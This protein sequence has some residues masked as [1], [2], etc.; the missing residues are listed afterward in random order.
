MGGFN[1]DMLK[2]E[3]NISDD[4]TPMAMIAVGYY[5]STDSLVEPY[6]ER[7]SAARERQPLEDNFRSSKY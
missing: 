2:A 5:G 7:E 6:R 3:F 1:S 4:F